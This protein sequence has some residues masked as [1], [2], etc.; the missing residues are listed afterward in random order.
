[1]ELGRIIDELKAEQAKLT[2]AIEALEGGGKDMRPRAR[3]VIGDGGVVRTVRDY[4][5]IQPFA[6]KVA[7]VSPPDNRSASSPGRRGV[8]TA[9]GRRRLSL[10]M[11]KRWAARHAAQA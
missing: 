11:K 10:A 6:L 3:K 5:K 9:D 8:L 4:A 1:M 7:P 2:A